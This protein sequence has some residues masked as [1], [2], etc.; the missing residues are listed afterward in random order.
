MVAC[1][2]PNRLSRAEDR[3]LESDAPLSTAERDDRVDLRGTSR[4]N[5]ARKQ[6]YEREEQRGRSERQRLGGTHAE[7]EVLE[8]PSQHEGTHPSDADSCEYEGQALAEDPSQ[9]GAEVRTERHPNTELVRPPRHGVRHDPV[10]PDRG[11]QQGEARKERQEKRIESLPADGLA[12]TLLKRLNL[13]NRLLF[14][15]RQNCRARR[16]DDSRG[17]LAVLTTT[18][19]SLKGSC[20]RGV[21]T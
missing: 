16:G 7:Q 14:V 17:P 2:R 9:H 6:G 5:P 18:K 21:Y 15:E 19:N 1:S 13:R 8:Q 20:A 10:Q 3:T 4:R 12:D 11:Q